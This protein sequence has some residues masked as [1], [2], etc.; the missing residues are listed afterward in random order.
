MGARVDQRDEIVRIG[1]VL[2][3]GARDARVCDRETS[4]VRAIAQR[5]DRRLVRRR[6]DR[7]D[8]ASGGRVEQ[9][10][11]PCN[12]PDRER[13]PVGADGGVQ[14]RCLVRANDAD[15]GRAPEQGAEQ[16]PARPHR[17]VERHAL[18]GE[19]ERAIELLVEQRARSESLGLGRGRLRAGVS[20]LLKCDRARDDR[21]DEQRA[22]TGEDGAQPALRALARSPALGEEDRLGGVEVRLVGG[23][24]VQRRCEAGAAVELT[25][26][27]AGGVPRARGARQMVVDPPALGVVLEPAAQARPLAQQRLVGHLDRTLADGDSRSSVSVSSTSATPSPGSSSKPT[28]RRTTASPSPGPASRSRI[29]RAISRCAGSS[30]P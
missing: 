26:I 9:E 14:E 22:D 5:L 24:P 1:R 27:A 3:G 25:G 13:S 29:R 19:Q 10:D 16:V 28:R 11:L 23:G 20:S 8:S 4:A 30:R 12:V 7:G 17:V 6:L 21:E 18:A 15:R 2:R